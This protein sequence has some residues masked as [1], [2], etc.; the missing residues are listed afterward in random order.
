[1]VIGLSLGLRFWEFSQ[2]LIGRTQFHGS[3]EGLYLAENRVMLERWAGPRQNCKA[4]ND[5]LPVSLLSALFLASDSFG[6]NHRNQGLFFSH[7][8]TLKCL[9]FSDSF[10]DQKQCSH[11]A[12]LFRESEFWWKLS[13]KNSFQESWPLP[14]NVSFSHCS[15]EAGG[16]KH[17]I[18]LN[19]DFLLFIA[20][21]PEKL[22]YSNW[23]ALCH[24]LIVK[25]EPII[26]YKQSILGRDL[27]LCL[28]H[29]IALTLKIDNEDSSLI[30][31]FEIILIKSSCNRYLQL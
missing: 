13:V 11:Y 14:D 8:T 31:F 24:P 16:K 5:C 9:P 19:L 26:Q 18:Y 3:Q 25:Y 27:V 22:V 17:S 4:E 30:S 15:P 28:N 21:H 10:P 29:R 7:L 20:C 1:M 23:G 6:D 2:S 12:S